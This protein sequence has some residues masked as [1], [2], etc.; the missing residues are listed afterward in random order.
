MVLTK[1]EKFVYYNLKF[2]IVTD[3]VITEFH[4]TSYQSRRKIS[5]PIPKMIRRFNIVSLIVIQILFYRLVIYD[6]INGVHF[7]LLEIF[8]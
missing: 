8:G 7:F 2:V 1:C 5:N 3:F 4:C 6:E